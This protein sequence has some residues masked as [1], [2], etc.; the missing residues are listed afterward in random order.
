[1]ICEGLGVEHGDGAGGGEAVAGGVV[2][3][4]AV[5]AG[6]G[7]VA[8]LGEGVEVEDADV[9]GGAGARD[10]EGAVGGVGG[11][12]VHTA[13]AADLDGLEDLV[14]AGLAWGLGM[15]KSGEWKQNGEGG[16]YEQFA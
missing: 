3:D 9:A 1:M 11:D 13:V 12:V 15:R 16:E 6:A 10:I 5:C 4:R 7:D 14:G 2:D 8:D